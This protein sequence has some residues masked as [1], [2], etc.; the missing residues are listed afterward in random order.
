MERDNCYM[1]RCFD[2]ARLGLGQVSPNPP[3]GAVLVYEDQIIGEGYHRRWGA[4]HAEVEAVA[5][6]PEHLRHLIPKATLYVS[7]EPC[8]VYGRTPPCTNLILDQGIKRVVVSCLDQS[9]EVAGRG[10]A[11]LRAGGVEV[12]TGV[13][14]DEGRWLVRFRSK[15]ATTGMPWVI[16]KF[17]RTRDGFMGLPERQV[18][19]SNP[20]T[21]R[22]VHRWRSE[23][24]A[25]MVATNTALIDNPRLTTRL[26]PG[27]SPVRVVLDRRGRLPEKL[28]LFD[29]TVPTWVVTEQPARFRGL[30][31]AP[32]ELGFDA[33]DFAYQLLKELGARRITSLLVEGG[34]ALLHYLIRE[35]CW[36]EARVFTGNKVLGTGVPAPEVHGRLMDEIH[37][38][39]NLLTLWANQ[40]TIHVK[41][42]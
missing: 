5:S 31:V 27:R 29:G 19:I 3:V 35:N 16:L 38:G 1:R 32:I 12:R 11:L 15:W 13:L 41:Q 36:D 37:I 4:P 14:E 7:L 26:W 6:V 23:L 34:S 33:P 28:H 9:P 17:A 10:V 2:L 20:L 24:D 8:C 39:D 40:V 18:W 25:I 30:P 42:G 22:L 21:L